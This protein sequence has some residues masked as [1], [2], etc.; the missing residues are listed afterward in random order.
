MVGSRRPAPS[1][2]S[3][4]R[5][6]ASR[7]GWP[8]RPGVGERPHPHHLEPVRREI[9]VPQQSWVTL[10]TAYGLIG[11]SSLVSWIGSSSGRVRPYSSFEPTTRMR[12]VGRVLRARFQQVD[13][14]DDV[15]Q[16]RG[17][18]IRQRLCHRRLAG[19]VVDRIRPGRSASA[20]S[21]SSRLPEIGADQPDCEDR[22][23]PLAGPAGSGPRPPDR[24]RRTDAPRDAG[25]RSRPL[26]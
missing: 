9:L 15:V 23:P 20:R 3:A 16:H 5:R 2:R 8:A 10:L 13:L 25:P 24:P 26:R 7:T 22:A 14:P 18:R 11:R 4:A 6:P 1:R 21:T 19:Q 12:A 17:E